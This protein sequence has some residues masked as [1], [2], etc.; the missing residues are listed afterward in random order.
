MRLSMLFDMLP[1]V[2]DTKAVL[3]C[4]RRLG[5]KSI[6]QATGSLSAPFIPRPQRTS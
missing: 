2:L 3:S 1:S 4:V 5:G 6:C